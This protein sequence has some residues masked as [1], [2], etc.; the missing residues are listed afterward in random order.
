[1]ATIAKWAWI[2]CVLVAVAVVLMRSWDDVVAMFRSMS[3]P[4]LAGGV[5]LTALAK[6]GLAENAR[7]AAV[8]ADVR[9]D[10][11][12]AARL[13]NLSQL[14]K[15]LPGSIWQFV[16]RAA[17]YRNLGASY[18][19]IRD[20]LLVESL[21][22]VAGAGV[23]GLVLTGPGMVAALVSGSLMPGLLWWLAAGSL[24]AALGG[25]ALALW[26]RSLI[27]H[28]ARICVPSFRAAA[29][30]A[31]I[32]LSLGVSFWVLAHACGLEVGLQTAIG[33]FAVAYA[34]GFLV[35]FAPAGLGVR[36]GILTL[37]LLPYAP[38]GEALAVTMLARM[39][40]L[41]VDVGLVLL[42]EPA[43]TVFARMK[44]FS[45]SDQ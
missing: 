13:Y 10:F 1:M 31:F 29:A 15:Y 6:V 8:R 26:K 14:G 36:D 40:Y 45:A 30:Q 22:I 9:I 32:W 2:A 42:Q 7:I 43:H 3:L 34:V 17:A 39:V 11:W 4:Y 44:H 37:G 25:V 41:V 16:G 20:A 19:A 27:V 21:W 5:G 28:F 12:T 38:A 23:F 24:I 18:A 33:L 35:P